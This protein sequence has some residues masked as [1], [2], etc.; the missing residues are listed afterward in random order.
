MADEEVVRVRLLLVQNT[1]LKAMRRRF[2]F[3]VREGAG[4]LSLPALSHTHTH[5]QHAGT[6]RG[7]DGGPADAGG[8]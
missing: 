3:I 5:T 4:G 8:S 2:G 1:E 7:K 6:G